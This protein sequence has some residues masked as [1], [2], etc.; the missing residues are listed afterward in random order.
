MWPGRLAKAVGQAARVASGLRRDDGGEALAGN[1]VGANDRTPPILASSAGEHKEKAPRARVGPLPAR[2]R[3]RAAPLARDRLSPR[4]LSR[5]I[6]TTTTWHSRCC[7]SATVPRHD[8]ILRPSPL[9]RAAT[10]VALSQFARRLQ[11]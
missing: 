11:I 10:S 5:L 7:L 9:V 3:A 2:A 8:S 1:E 6:S 4:A